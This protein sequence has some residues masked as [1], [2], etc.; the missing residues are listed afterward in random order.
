M[1][2]SIELIK[3]SV[4]SENYCE[5]YYNHDNEGLKMKKITIG[6]VG[7]GT[8]GTGVIKILRNN[9]TLISQRL[10]TPIEIKKIVDLDIKSD[11]GI[12]LRKGLLSKNV[13]DIINDPSIDLIVE[14]IGGVESAKTILLDA[15]KRGKHIVTANKAQAPCARVKSFIIKL[16]NIWKSPRLTMIWTA[17]MYF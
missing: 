16:R 17:R 8:V 4:E 5:R 9:K 12:R 13:N 2:M 6:I 3:L 1:K 10:G 11:R 14:L 15:I 7:F